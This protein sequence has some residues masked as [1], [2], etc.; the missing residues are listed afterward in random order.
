M[1]TGYVTRRLA[2]ATLMVA[3]LSG[4][5]AARIEPGLASIATPSRAPA[6]MPA[7]RDLPQ[8]PEVVVTAPRV[9]A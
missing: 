1:N 3:A 6:P 2:I 5:V 4:I 8:L 7:Y 9:G